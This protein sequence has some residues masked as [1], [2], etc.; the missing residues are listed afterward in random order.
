MHGPE[1]PEAR[2][3]DC[4]ICM[5]RPIKC[6]R[7]S[8]EPEVTY[9]KPAGIPLRELKELEI[10]VDELEALKL[11]DFGGLGQTAASKKMGISQPTLNRLLA[12]VRRK[13]AEALAKGLAIKIRGGSYYVKK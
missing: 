5:P 12:S 13:I 3:F 2:A 10:G 7:V 11:V 9:F 1:K 6:R 8:F 4:R